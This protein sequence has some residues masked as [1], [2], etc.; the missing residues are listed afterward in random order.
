MKIVLLYPRME[1]IKEIMTTRP[2]LGLAYLAASL[3]REGHEVRIIDLNIEKVDMGE[4]IKKYDLI[5]IS[6]LTVFYNEV[7]NLIKK[8]READKKI[9]IVLGGPHITMMTKQVME[10]NDVNFAVRYEGEETIVELARELEQKKDF[11]KIKGLAYKDKDRVI[12]NQD[13]EFNKNLDGI[14]M[15]ARH[16]L[17]IN[18]YVSYMENEKSTTILTSRGCPYACVYCCKTEGRMWRA[19]SAKRV[20]DEMEE[21]YKQY[22]IKV[23]YIE[24]DLFTLDKKRVIEICGEIK[25]RELNIKW[26]CISRVDNV[27]IET[28]KAMKGAGCIEINYGVESGDE[29][30]LKKV[31]KGI[32]LEQAENAFR[33]TKEAGI[34]TKGYFIIGLPWDTKETVEKTIE[35]AT[36]LNA[37]EIQ[38]S[39]CTPLPGTPLWELAI[40]EDALNPNEVNWDNFALMSADIDGKVYFTKNLTAEE[41][42]KLRKKAYRKLITRT[43]LRKIKEGDIKTILG[44]I[45]QKR[46]VGLGKFVRKVFL[47]LVC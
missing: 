43:F 37:D 33:T 26:I 28:L 38:F 9:P 30:V 27:D 14:P 23:I 47:P 7:K 15:P 4:E 32:T 29:D 13:R 35:F 2:P 24:D 19:M 5:G 39:I 3:E 17:K 40:K 12:I 21:I 34:K 31:G 1:N 41:I 6:V 16:L 45:N 22:N 10:E 46:R 25:K 18:E 36:K 44:I 11:S 20:V 8:I 42:I